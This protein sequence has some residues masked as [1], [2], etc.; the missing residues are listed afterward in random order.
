MQLTSHHATAFL[1]PP[2][3]AIED[4][5]R[6]WDP[7]MQRQIAAHIT[8]V[9]PNEIADP[10]ELLERVARAAARIAP[11]T[12]AVGPAFYEGSPT[13]GVFLGVSDLHDG[14]S[15][16]RAV[17]VPEAEAISFP[18]H[19]TIVHPRTSNRGEQAWA[20]LAE[21]HVD[22]A[23]TIGEVAMTA[24]DGDRWLTLQTIPLTG[25]AV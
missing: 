4:L 11:F 15:R 9:Y 8:L 6:T 25:S 13:D 20:K 21:I 24:Y 3:S 1:D 23:F 14:L 16:F 10:A 19:V 12:V 7:E 5:R 17:A 2:S 22:A 18:P